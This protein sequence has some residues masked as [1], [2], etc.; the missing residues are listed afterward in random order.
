MAKNSLKIQAQ[1]FPAETIPVKAI[2]D[3]RGL[4]VPLQI[5]QSVF[6]YFG[7]RLKARFNSL[8]RRWGREQQR[9]FTLTEVA[10]A[11]GLFGF[12]NAMQ[13]QQAGQAIRNVRVVEAAGI[14]AG[15]HRA[16]RQYAESFYNTVQTQTAVEPVEIT[17]ATLMANG[18]LSP[19]MV[20][21]GVVRDSFG[22]VYHA[23]ARQT[24]GGG[25]ELMTAPRGGNTVSSKE[26]AL[27]SNILSGGS[28]RD[29]FMGGVTHADATFCGAMDL[30]ATGAGGSFVVDI[31]GFKTPA[32]TPILPPEGSVVTWE[33]V[34]SSDVIGPQLYRAAVPGRPEANMMLT[35]LDMGGNA[36]N[37]VKDILLENGQ[38]VAAS[39]IL[40]IGD[41]PAGATVSKNGCS[42]AAPTPRIFTSVR[43]FADDG[44]GGVSPVAAVQTFA[45]DDPMDPSNSWVLRMRVLTE[46]G[47]STPP[48]DRGRI[49]FC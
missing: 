26:L 41:A 9:A 21:G 34:G 44:M 30:C 24:A 27:A 42:D 40:E 46:S 31:N 18:F 45:E 25:I 22:R 17:A 15:M 4:P 2:A 19:N 47:F 28:D 32:T 49:T 39:T 12:L 14:H 7:G 6:G 11:V 5:D 43:A 29:G 13:I 35:D 37:N 8:I 20:Q 36:L 33:T 3:G 16:L 48:A 38:S 10:V 23:L 1:T